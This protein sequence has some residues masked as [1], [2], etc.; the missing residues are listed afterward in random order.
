MTSDNLPSAAPSIARLVQELNRLPG[1][2]PKSAQRLAYHIIRLPEEEAYALAEAVTAVKQNT[3]FCGECQ[4]LAEVTPCTVCADGRRS[5]TIIC[6]VEDPMDVLA[7]ERTRSFRGLYHVLHGVISPINGVGPDQ[8]KL[9]EL[10][11]RLQDPEVAELVVATNPTMEGEATAM[12]IQRHLGRDDLRVTR[13]A[14]GLPV[15][16]SLEHTDETT[17]SRAFQGRQEL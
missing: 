17:L 13:L 1:I 10:L 12:Y 5:R 6:V 8:L 14:R 9:R 15:G 2:G 4:N 7:L 11:T 3:I 16:G